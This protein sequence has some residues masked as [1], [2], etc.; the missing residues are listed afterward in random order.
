MQNI[1]LDL[2]KLGGKIKYM[3]GVNNGPTSPN[4]R[5][6]ATNF[7]LYK[8]AEFSFARL[9]DSSFF[10]GYGGDFSVDVHRIFRNFDADVNDPASYIFEPTDDYIKNLVASGTKV[11]YRLGASI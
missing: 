5:G 3:N 7:D 2:A 9:H 6:T 1:K 10:T 4:V 8:E 11:F